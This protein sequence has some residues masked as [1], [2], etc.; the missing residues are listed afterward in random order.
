MNDK[1]LNDNKSLLESDF[2]IE[3]LEVDFEPF[4]FEVEPLEIDFEP[5][6]F[7]FEKN[8]NDEL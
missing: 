3:P 1:K 4:E 5:L 6:E 7:D 2:E 8:D